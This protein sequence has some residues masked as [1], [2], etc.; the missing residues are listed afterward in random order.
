MIRVIHGAGFV[1]VTELRSLAFVALALVVSL[2]LSGLLYTLVER[3]A[4][5]R[6][7]GSRRPRAQVE[8]LAE[9]ARA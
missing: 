3:P 8:A 9:P 4:E 2:V 1:P 7:R 6:L 5:R